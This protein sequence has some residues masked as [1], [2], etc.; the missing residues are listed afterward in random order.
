MSVGILSRTAGNFYVTNGRVDRSFA[1]EKQSP[2]HDG[3]MAAFEM[4]YSYTLDDA[5]TILLYDF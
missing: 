3:S 2:L 1:D 4:R 5:L